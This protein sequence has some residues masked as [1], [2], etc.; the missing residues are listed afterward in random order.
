MFWVSVAGHDPAEL[1]GKL[2]GRVPLV[3]LKDKAAD[4]PFASTKASRAP[5]SKRSATARSTG[6]RC[7]APPMPP[8]CSTTSWSRTRLPG[9]PIESLRQS[10]AFITK[11][12]Y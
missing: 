7:C 4:T 1:L 8:E 5:R 2:K 10:F 12:T 3:H 6:P 9:D 11:V